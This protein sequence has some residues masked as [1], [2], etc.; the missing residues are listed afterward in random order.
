LYS[1]LP[2]LGLVSFVPTVILFFILNFN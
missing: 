2:I 1:L